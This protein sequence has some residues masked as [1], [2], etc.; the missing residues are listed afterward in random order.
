MVMDLPSGRVNFGRELDAEEFRGQ[1]DK[2]E[3]FRLLDR[4]HLVGITLITKGSGDVIVH[5]Y[6]KLYLCLAT[7]AS[8]PFN[9]ALVS[10]FFWGFPKV[11]GVSDIG[12]NFPTCLRYCLYSGYLRSERS[13]VIHVLA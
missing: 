7:A 5:S 13:S 11:G 10:S 6:L 9:A 3:M 2:A 8:S 12:M 4:L 1:R